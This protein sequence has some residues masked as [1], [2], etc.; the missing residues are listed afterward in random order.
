MNV[1]LV[2]PEINFH[3]FD[4]ISDEQKYSY[5]LLRDKLKEIYT[6]LELEIEPVC[7][8]DTCT[9]VPK[10]VDLSRISS[11]MMNRRRLLSMHSL[12]VN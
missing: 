5:S 1:E 7:I 6:N 2:D 12:N 11:S 8:R 4:S 9:I 10:S 3:L